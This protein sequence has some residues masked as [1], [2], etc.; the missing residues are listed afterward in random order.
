LDKGI[1][2]KVEKTMSQINRRIQGKAGE[3]LAASFLEQ[4]GFKIIKRNYRF[5]RGEI[6]LIAEEGDELVFIEVK[7]RRSTAYGTPEDAVTEEKQE[8]VHT[9]AEGYLFEHD[10]DN[11]PCRFDVVAIEFKNDK[12]DIRHIRNAF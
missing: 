4:K 9:V 12:A 10:I 11:R 5:E 7:A 8:Q 6:D 2:G 3:D 1:F